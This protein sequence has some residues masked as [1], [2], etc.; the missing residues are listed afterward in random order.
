MPSSKPFQ[1]YTPLIYASLLALGMFMG[2]KLYESVRG[3]TNATIA[4][5]LL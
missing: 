2:F 1:V 5:A 4:M 3:R